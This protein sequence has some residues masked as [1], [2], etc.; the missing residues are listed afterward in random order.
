MTPIHYA[1]Q[2]T[3]SLEELYALSARPVLPLFVIA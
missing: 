1:D 3:E 2:I